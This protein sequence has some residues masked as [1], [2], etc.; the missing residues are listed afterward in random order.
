[1]HAFFIETYLGQA[2]LWSESVRHDVCQSPTREIS[3]EASR[4]ECS[5]P[6]LVRSMLV[7][8]CVVDSRFFVLVSWSGEE[9]ARTLWFS[10]PRWGPKADQVFPHRSPPSRLCVLLQQPGVVLR[11]IGRY[12]CPSVGHTG[13]DLSGCDRACGSFCRRPP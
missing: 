7:F 4:C 2:I 5:T 11:S 1:M 6:I 9:P 13:D 8:Q 3:N 12:S 10:P